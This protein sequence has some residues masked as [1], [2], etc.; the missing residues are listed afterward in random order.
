MLHSM[1]FQLKISSKYEYYIVPSVI[2][3]KIYC[4]QNLLRIEFHLMN[5]TDTVCL[6]GDLC[7]ECDAFGQFDKRRRKRRIPNVVYIALWQ[8]LL[9]SLVHCTNDGLH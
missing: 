6:S 9:P 8:T 2:I 4:L 7:I 1:C 5:A 3:F